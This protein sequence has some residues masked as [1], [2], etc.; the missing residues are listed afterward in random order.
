MGLARIDVDRQLVPA[1]GRG[2][3]GRRLDVQAPQH[4]AH[5]CHELEVIERLGDIVVGAGLE[6]A[7]LVDRLI[8]RGQHDHGH[9]AEGADLA[10]DAVAVH[11][12]QPDVEQD[13]VGPLL[14]DQR[15][16]L[17][18]GSRLDDLHVAPLQLE[19]EPN[20]AADLGVVVDEEKLHDRP[21][22]GMTRWKVLPRPTSLSTSMP[23]PWACAM[24]SAVGRP[25]P[26]PPPDTMPSEVPTKKR[27]KS[28]ARSLA[29]MPG[30]RSTTVQRTVSSAWRV[31]RRSISAPAG[32]VEERLLEPAPISRHPD[33]LIR[34]LDP[35]AL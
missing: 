21:P 23:P 4:R 7:H 33:R 32:E 12:G 20:G 27:S 9:R 35:D 17:G 28:L 13:E 25:I 5:A 3:L 26:E 14:L 24:A 29:S 30:P 2:A 22:A 31:R 34:E 18:S 10:Q 6:T 11:V 1:I 8:P 15:Q 16:R 19:S